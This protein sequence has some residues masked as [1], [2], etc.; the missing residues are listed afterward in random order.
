[1][2]PSYYEYHNPVK[3]LSG[4][5]ACENI[6]HELDMMGVSRP[7]IITDK[8]VSKAGLLNILKKSFKNSKIIPGAIYDNTPPDSSVDTVNEIAKIYNAKKCDSIIAIGGGSPI[9]TAKGVNIVVSEGTDDLLN[10]SGVNR[11]KIDRLMTD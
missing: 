6:P 11:I 5:K 3:I 7:I 2:I 1:M 8:G 10:Y 9:D 4:K